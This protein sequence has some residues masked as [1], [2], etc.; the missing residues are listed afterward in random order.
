MYTDN[1]HYGGEM[2]QI[3][4]TEFRR[5]LFE[6]LDHIDQSPIE[7]MRHGRAVARIV[8]IE[9]KTDAAKQRLMALR[10][11]AKIV[12]IETPLEITWTYDEEHLA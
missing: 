9:N 2:L 8:P 5:H 7:L 3:N 6:Y 12:D 10:K 4:T 11:T 1:V